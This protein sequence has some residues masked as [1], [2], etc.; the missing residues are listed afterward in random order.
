M[1][2]RVSMREALAD[3]E[4]FGPIMSGSSLVSA[5]RSCLIAS[6]GEP[7]TDDEREEFRRL[8]GR[9]REPLRLC[10]ELIVIAGRRAGKSTAMAVFAI[11]IA[12]ACAIIATFWRRA[13][14]ASCCWSRATSA[15]AGCLL[16]R[17]EGIMQ[18]REPLGS[19]DLQPHGRYDRA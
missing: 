13:R 10:R 1:R 2:V 17:I 11:W 5:G 19:T 8:T 3:P 9:E 18:A 15:S 7:L 6:A 4:L 16:D 14:L 12:V